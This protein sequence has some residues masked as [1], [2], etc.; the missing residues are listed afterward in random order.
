MGLCEMGGVCVVACASN[1][2]CI[3]SEGEMF[4]TSHRGRRNCRV[5]IGCV[6]MGGCVSKVMLTVC[7]VG[8][9]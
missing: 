2:E 3:C 9:T 4:C 5:R 7:F 6:Y 8:N 1:V